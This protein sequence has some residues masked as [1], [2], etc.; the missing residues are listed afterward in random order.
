MFSL[1]ARGLDDP[2]E[3]RC[4]AACVALCVSYIALFSLFQ[5]AGTRIDDAFFARRKAVLLHRLL[6]D[7]LPLNVPVSLT[8]RGHI[9]PSFLLFGGWSVAEPWGVWTDGGHADLAVALPNA[10]DSAP[11]LQLW[12][13]L[14]LPPSGIQTLRLQT[15]GQTI[16]SWRLR[17]RHAVLCAKLPSGA[18]S[19]TGIV[20]IGIEIGSPQTPEGGLDR[21]KLGLG[22]ERVELLPQTS[23]CEPQAALPSN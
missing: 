2:R 19:A 15:G 13:T 17:S 4:L 10:G 7:R 6:A 22:L 1:I 16:G 21:R 23:Q 9:A 18:A 11:V 8:D 5:L 3:R 14:E 12:A 20:Q